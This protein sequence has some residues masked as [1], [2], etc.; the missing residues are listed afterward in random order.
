KKK[1]KKKK[2]KICKQY[3]NG[4]KSVQV[5]PID[6]NI[7]EW[8]VKFSNFDS[9]SAIYLD[10][11][12]LGNIYGEEWNCV[13]MHVSFLMELFPIYPPKVRLVRPRLENF[14]FGRI[15]CMEELQVAKWN[16]VRTL[17]DIFNA[18]RHLI[19]KAGHVDVTNPV[20]NPSNERPPFTEMEYQ[21]LR[22]S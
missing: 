5:I 6:D 17:E 15:V 2:K 22:L 11:M 8:K 3:D 9:E 16:P 18:I 13:E 10:L 1:K 20:N 12:K 19:L 21:L 14:M 4:D 7:Y